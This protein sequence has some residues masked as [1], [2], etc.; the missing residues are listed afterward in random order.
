ML[1]LPDP[2]KATVLLTSGKF[3]F[4]IQIG[5]GVDL[6]VY[7]KTENNL[8]KH[9]PDFHPDTLLIGMKFPEGWFYVGYNW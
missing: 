1:R 2:P 3:G 4:K 5:V 7:F 6:P 8:P 9:D